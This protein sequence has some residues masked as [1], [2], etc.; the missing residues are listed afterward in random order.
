MMSV[1]GMRLWQ[2][3]PGLDLSQA[4]VRGQVRVE[5]VHVLA[6]CLLLA[7]LAIML[8]RLPQPVSGS[9]GGNWLALSGGYLGIQANAAA[10]VY[11]PGFLLLLLL[12]R[13]FA[14]PVEAL[15][16]AAALVALLPGLGCYVLLRSMR[17][18]YMAL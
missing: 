5:P 12:L 3:V 8:A 17:L 14:P 6:G 2:V 16:L 1:R 4:R 7:V 10:T 9:D 15:R 11:P 18:R 13:A